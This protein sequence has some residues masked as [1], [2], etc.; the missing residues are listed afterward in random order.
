MS[1]CF[2]TGN[3]LLRFARLH[4]PAL[5]WRNFM[6]DNVVCNTAYMLLLYRDFQVLA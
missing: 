5:V 4:E 6:E 2:F 3:R 1:F